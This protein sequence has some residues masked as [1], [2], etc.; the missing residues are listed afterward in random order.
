MEE[1]VNQVPKKGN[2]TECGNWRGAMILNTIYKVMTRIIG[3]RI[4]SHIQRTIRDEQ[5][6]YRPFRSHSDQSNTLR[7]IIEQS[8]EYGTPLYVA[9]V[10]FEKAFDRV[11]RGAVWL[12]LHRRNIPN[13]IIRLIRALN[14]DTKCQVLH[15]RKLS[16]EFGVTAGLRQGCRLSLLL[17]LPVIDDIM[18]EAI[19]STQGIQW[20]ST[21]KLGYLAY[22]DDICLLSN[23]HDEIQLMLNRLLATALKCGLKMNDHKTKIM[24]IN[25]NDPRPILL[26]NSSRSIEQ[27][28]KYCY[29]GRML[30]TNGGTSEDIEQRIVAATSSFDKLGKIW[31][32]SDLFTSNKLRIFKA[33]VIETLLYGCE[34]WNYTAGEI[35]TLKTFVDDCLRNIRG[36]FYPRTPRTFHDLLRFTMDPIETMI[37]RKK[38]QWIAR[39]RSR[40]NDHIIKQALD[41]CPHDAAS[42]QKTKTT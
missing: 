5:A 20:N 26:S 8:V 25:A 28:A 36:I 12:A 32:S 27:V 33:V 38:G 1:S 4:F 23:S 22:A 2:L 41:W 13:K 18:N 15:N 3:N 37:N 6:A 19:P 17:F 21:R 11:D 14:D 7:L 39:I 42:I 31:E 30:S 16:D 9:F 29:V 10:D 24:K 40:P 35:I 34:T